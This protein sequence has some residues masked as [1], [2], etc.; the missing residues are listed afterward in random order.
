MS[1]KIKVIELEKGKH[2]KYEILS[3]L[4]HFY[5][6]KYTLESTRNS[7]DREVFR[8]EKI[9]NENSYNQS[10]NHYLDNYTIDVSNN[11]FNNNFKNYR[12]DGVL[13]ASFTFR[14]DSQTVFMSYHYDYDINL[15]T[16][17]I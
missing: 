12:A 4:I 16:A 7:Y 3:L 17:S 8:F 14:Y 6:N 1:E 15:K 11:D 9:S 10:E 5:N 13:K 2:K